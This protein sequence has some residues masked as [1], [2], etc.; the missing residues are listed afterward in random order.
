MAFP[1]GWNRKCSIVIQ[2]SKVPADLS[3][4]PVLLTEDCLPSE[5]L[6][7]DGSYPALEGGADIRFTSDTEGVTPLHREVV[8]CVL[9]NDPSNA[10][11]EIWVNVP[12]V[13]HDA[14]TT[15]YVWYNNA[16]ATEPDPDDADHGRHGVWDSNYKTVLHMIGATA[17]DIDDST[18]NNNDVSGENGTP[19][20]NQAGQIK[21]CIGCNGAD[22]EYIYLSSAGGLNNLQTGT[23]SLWVQWSGT[24]DQGH[25]DAYGGLTS[26][27]KSGTFSNQI[28][29]LNGS[30]PD[31]AVITWR[32][33]GA[34]TKNII[35]ATLL[36]VIVSESLALCV[37]AFS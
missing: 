9:D 37:E 3:N 34:D 35:G 19:T 17:T 36:I 23:I 18:S 16:S 6:D 5:M 13:D 24:Q 1:T 28:I 21:Q 15:I 8:S 33:Y 20:Y 30:D 26:R 32:C 12:V 11:A 27:Q 14:N 25:G 31:S 7:K 4:F 10:T 29:S 22:S 2:S